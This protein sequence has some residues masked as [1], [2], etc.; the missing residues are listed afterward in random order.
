MD[1]AIAVQTI[2]VTTAAKTPAPMTAAATATAPRRS[3]I[4]AAA[5]WAS[6]VN[7]DRAHGR[8]M[9]TACATMATARASL[10]GAEN[11]AMSSSASTV[12]S[13]TRQTSANV[14]LDGK[15][16]YA[17]THYAPTTALTTVCAM[18]MDAVRVMPTGLASTVPCARVQMTAV[19]TALAIS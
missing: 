9:A 7:S 15:G 8:A 18:K 13:A 3:A 12:C 14:I 17:Q 2:P 19:S 6:H 4:A 16:W 1:S 5:T 10:A 11:P